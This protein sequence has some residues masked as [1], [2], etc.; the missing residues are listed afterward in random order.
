[1]DV[2]EL[3]KTIDSG[4]AVLVLVWVL[5]RTL[6]QQRDLI[7]SQQEMMANMLSKLDGDEPK[8]SPLVA[9]QL[10]P[11]SQLEGPQGSMGPECDIRGVKDDK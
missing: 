11:D 1:M 8:Y 7:N 3:L 4:I 9:R 2:L 5:G 6:N 10:E